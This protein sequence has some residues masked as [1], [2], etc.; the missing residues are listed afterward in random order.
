MKTYE[1]PM[2]ITTT[3]KSDQQKRPHSSGSES[4]PP[5][6]PV[7]E[8]KTWSRF[9]LI[10][11]TDD[12]RPLSHCHAV[13]IEKTITGQIGCDKYK[14][15]RLRNGNL[16]VEV[17]MERHSRSVSKLTR[18]CCNAIQYP[19][20][21][22]PHR[23]L[24][25]S[26][27]VVRCPEFKLFE[28]NEIVDCLLDQ[29]VSQAHR[30]NI[31]K[32]GKKI[33]TGTV[34]LTF[35]TP[36]LPPKI[37]V[38]FLMVRVDPYIPNPMRCF[39]CQRYGHTANRCK[40]SSVCAVCAEEGHD[41]RSCTNPKKCANCEGNHP[42]F[43]KDCP[44][45]QQEKQ[46]QVIKV[47]QKLSYF[48]AKKVVLGTVT[49]A[50]YSRAVSKKTTVTVSTQTEITAIHE[51]VCSCRSGARQQQSA[52]NLLTLQN[53]PATPET[54]S[55]HS[56]APSKLPVTVKPTADA[57]G[58]QKNINQNSSKPQINRPTSDGIKQRSNSSSRKKKKDV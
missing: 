29:G 56:P 55:T 11:G 12:E 27:G 6:S 21:V 13:A 47:Q 3:T 40:R 24:N 53:S 45:W 7:R 15:T 17:E 9:L 18:I 54:R 19:V 43:S 51:C 33:P 1:F 14:V 37:K 26:R 10:S 35:N 52:D 30:I 39:K 36:D 49:S 2:E 48:E 28:E 16:L 5:P 31:N 50:T 32:D 44:Q 22:E 4:S 20:K 57:G 25:S 38:G 8:N 46:I 34:I 41:D 58:A 42:V 23:S